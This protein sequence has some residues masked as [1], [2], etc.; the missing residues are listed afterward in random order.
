MVRQRECQ[1]N[2]MKADKFC[3]EYSQQKHLSLNEGRF[4]ALSF[5]FLFMISWSFNCH[6]ISDIPLIR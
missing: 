6:S 4:A 1:R 5:A 2:E 3:R